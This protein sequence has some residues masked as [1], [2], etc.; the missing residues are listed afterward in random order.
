[1]KT[2][3]CRQIIVGILASF[4]ISSPVRAFEDP[5]LFPQPFLLG[6]WNF[7]S[8]S[9][10]H[11][12]SFERLQLTLDS[13]YQFRFLV[14]QSDQSVREWRGVYQAD[15]ANLILGA[16]S[17]TPQTYHYQFS[18][19]QLVLDGVHFTKKLP[20]PLAGVWSSNSLTDN[21]GHPTWLTQ[22]D[23]RLQPDFLFSMTLRGSGGEHQTRTGIF[24]I[25]KQ[26]L[27][28][29]Y[30]LGEESSRYQVRRNQLELISE[31]GDVVAK[32]KRQVL[33]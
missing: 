23:L 3:V 33:R 30:E 24:Y 26:Y 25:D 12:V 18:H 11:P 27:V 4:F 2:L 17:S 15:R 5:S 29:L 13:D 32:L 10:E 21:K 16:N 31:S 9:H 7:Y 19:N 1:M 28:F 14:Y 6:D 8:K 22:L 20:S